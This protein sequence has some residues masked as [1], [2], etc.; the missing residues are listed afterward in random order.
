MPAIVAALLTALI[1][2]LLPVAA[3]DHF[4]RGFMVQYEGE[5]FAHVLASC[6]R[7]STTC[8]S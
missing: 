5:V 3:Q 6:A 7:R 4:A 2:W 1:G 8:W